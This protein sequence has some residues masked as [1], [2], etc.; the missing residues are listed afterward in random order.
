[1]SGGD[2]CGGMFGVVGPELLVRMFTCMPAESVRDLSR[3]EI[4]Q[5]YVPD[6]ESGGRRKDG[7]ASTAAGCLSHLYC[8]SWSR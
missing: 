3:L 1:M 8:V 6:Q 7:R 4:R 2:G 5:L